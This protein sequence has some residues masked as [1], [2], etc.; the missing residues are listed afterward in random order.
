MN[1]DHAMTCFLD[2]PGGRRVEV[3]MTVT[4]DPLIPTPGE[5]DVERA[6]HLHEWAEI[7]HSLAS[8]NLTFKTSKP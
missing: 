5:P 7:C 4:E 6:P 8:M 1:S 3:G 2:L